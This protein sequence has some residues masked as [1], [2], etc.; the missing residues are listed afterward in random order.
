[1]IDSA[2]YAIARVRA[3]RR[4]RRRRRVG[5][6]RRL[7]GFVHRIPSLVSRARSELALERRV[8]RRANQA[9]GWIIRTR[10]VIAIQIYLRQT[11]FRA[12]TQP[13]VVVVSVIVVIV[14]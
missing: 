9:R 4:R 13:I 12:G 2:T 1:V 14:A 8:P 11:C 10:R 3:A 7:G 6:R 5:R